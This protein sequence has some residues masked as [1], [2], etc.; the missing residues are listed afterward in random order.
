[1]QGN[2]RFKSDR[3]HMFDGEID[4]LEDELDMTDSEMVRDAG[5]RVAHLRD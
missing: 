4:D 1:M 2:R 5:R 3:T